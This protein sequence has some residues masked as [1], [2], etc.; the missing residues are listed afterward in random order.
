MDGVRS[1]SGSMKAL[2]L[3][4]ITSTRNM[5]GII[6]QSYPYTDNNS[7]KLHVQND[8]IGSRRGLF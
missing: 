5:Y 8:L 1:N 7:Y 6:T 3:Q 2:L 4:N